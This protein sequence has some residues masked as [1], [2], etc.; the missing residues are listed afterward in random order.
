MTDPKQ[1]IEDFYSDEENES[2]Q[3]AFSMKITVSGQVSDVSLIDAVAARFNTTRSAIVSDILH[4]S[5]REMWFALSESDKE[6]ISY[7]ADLETTKVLD[8]KGV[9]LTTVGFG[10]DKG[11][12]ASDDRTW[13]GYYSVWKNSKL[14]GGSEDDNS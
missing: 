1:L 11:E 12:V 10:L 7:G 9:T 13:R 14:N 5:A 2:H 6:S 3:E 8:K 4:D